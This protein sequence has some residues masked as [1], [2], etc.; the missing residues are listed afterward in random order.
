[1]SSLSDRIAL[2]E[3]MLRERG[4]E[5]PLA[6]HPP[7]T[8]HEAQAGI[9]E[10]ASIDDEKPTVRIIEQSS[11][12]PLSKTS[13]PTGSL[14][15]YSAAMYA[16]ESVG[17]SIVDP[18]RFHSWQDEACAALGWLDLDDS[19]LF[20]RLFSAKESLYF[21]RSSGQ[22]R[23]YGSTTD[24]HILSQN[25]RSSDVHESA[26]LV[27]RAELLIRS[28][29]A[30]THDHLMQ[31]FWTHYNSVLEVVHRS[32]FEADHLSQKTR[33]YSSFLHVCMLSMGLRFADADREDVKAIKCG[34][35]ESTF[36]REA[37][38]MIDLDR[39]GGIP[40]I[41]ALLL[42]S[43]L[44]C[45]VGR[46]HTG[47]IYAGTANRI[48]FDIGLH[49]KC[50]KNSG[51]EFVTEEGD[52]VGQMVMRACVLYDKH[53]ALFL[54]RPMSIKDHDISISLNP[55]GLSQLTS[56]IHGSSVAQQNDDMPLDICDQLVQLMRLAGQV[57]EAY[58][59]PGR[60]KLGGDGGFSIFDADGRQTKAYLQAVS[61]DRQLQTWYKRL[62]ERLQWRPSVVKSAPPSYFLLHQQ[63][64]VS[65]ILL[66]RP[67]A[68]YDT[69]VEDGSR[70]A[71]LLSYSLFSAS[72]R[73]DVPS[74]LSPATWDS[75]RTNEERGLPSRRICAQQA[76]RVARI[77]SQQEG[78]FDGTKMFITAIQH[79][80]TA[81]AALIAALSCEGDSAN[82]R[83]YFE[84]LE[85]LSHAIGDM[86][87][88]Y[89]PAA[90]IYVVVK[91]V[92]ARLESWIIKKDSDEQR[93]PA[94]ALHS[95]DSRSSSTSTVDGDSNY[96]NLLGRRRSEAES[97]QPYKKRRSTLSSRRASDFSGRPSPFSVMTETAVSQSLHGRRTLGGHAPVGPTNCATN[98]STFNLNLVNDCAAEH[99]DGKTRRELGVHEDS[100]IGRPL[101]DEWD[102]DGTST[103]AFA[104]VPGQSLKQESP[105]DTG[106]DAA[107]SHAL[108]VAD[109]ASVGWTTEVGEMEADLLGSVSL[110]RL[111]EIAMPRRVGTKLADARRNHE[112]DFLA[113]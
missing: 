78:R 91:G 96:S 64:H 41:Q 30:A 23:Y 7:K 98:N 67:W 59:G 66:H 33:F 54:G 112:L 20:R 65:V 73:K 105:D 75:E 8:R 82:R 40:T 86:S 107:T 74:G 63:Y 3:G 2:L 92:L 5:P 88:T 69:M 97:T 12:S 95:S 80:G 14:H 32:A 76:I 60:D 94:P 45:G 109:K 9:R 104:D 4:I 102:L 72:E 28:M 87:Q 46:D 11:Y 55:R 84:H 48:A 25:S 101:F 93:P 85:V 113:L 36:H 26:E 22:S 108:D 18:Q 62:P 35:H 77:F 6:A 10:Y 24:S 21:D 71:D 43:D 58:D 37:K 1:M 79:A 16:S 68:K 90:R 42:L 13:S 53:W 106:Y 100:L 89:Q 103:V 81:A 34:V 110:G 49:R 52:N 111:V 27:G 39:P 15:R 38:S 70:G 19:D 99:D 51:T 31:T 56:L 61:L 47:W 29:T 50:Q 44:E 83:A 57:A 17:S